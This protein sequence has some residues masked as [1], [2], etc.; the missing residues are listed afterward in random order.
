M[1]GTVRDAL[2]P[3]NQR[4]TLEELTGDLDL[5]HG[6]VHAKR[7]AFWTMLTL[8]AVIA[9]AGV[10]ADSTA[11]VIGAMIIAPLSTPI[12][13]IALSLVKQEANGGFR[14]ALLGG[15]TVIAVGLLFALV[16][17]G[18][19]DL[20]GNDQIAGRTSPGVLDLVA[21]V[22]TGLAGAV[23]LARRDVAAVLPGVAISISLVPPLA[24]VGICAG[25][26][27]FLLAVGALLLFLSNLLALVLSGTLVFAMLGYG[28]D[29]ARAGRPTRRARITVGALLLLIALPLVGNT[30]A[31]YALTLWEARVQSA[32][33]EW[34]EDIPG[35]TITGVDNVSTTFY[36]HVRAPVELPPVEE[37]MADV[38]GVVPDGFRVVVVSSRGEELASRT[39]GE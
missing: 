39:V 36:V 1:N 32:A 6:D 12:M 35:A 8:S 21:A 7:T 2:L 11:T 27:S 15:T 22:A 34:V 9:S 16:L 37:L 4:R 33:G 29:G 17:P 18:T 10:L 28:P 3:E 14:F 38:E 19:Y 24:V 23:A 31:S 13:G 25:Q 5:N 30:I 26:G 20:V